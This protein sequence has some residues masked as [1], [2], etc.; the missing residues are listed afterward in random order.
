MGSVEEL[1]KERTQVR[2]DLLSGK[3]PKRVFCNP[4]FTM[5]AACDYAGINLMEA[6]YSMELTEKAY[7]K[8]CAD[9]IADCMPARNI[10]FATIYQLLGARNWITSSNGTIQHPEIETMK[11]EDYDEFIAA[12][13]KTIMGKFLPRVCAA[14]DKDPVS[15]TLNLATAYGAYKNITAAQGAVYARMGAKYG[16]VPGMITNQP[17]EAPFDFLA[18][19]LRGFKAI[20]MD[21]RRCPDKVKGAVEAI[22]P[23]MIKMATPP[24]IRPGMLT[25]IP[26][27][28]APYISMKA[29]DELYW[30]TFEKTIVDLDKIGI[31]C[32]LF[33]EQDWTRYCEYLER[34]PK[35]TVM[36]MESGDPKRFTETVG[37][38]HVFGGFYDPTITLSRS[39]E[40][41]IDEVKKLLDTCMKSDHFYFTFDKSVIDMKSVNV[42]KLQAVCEWVYE[43]GKY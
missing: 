11:V 2:N 17:I 1:I 10:R 7:D 5:E 29:F 18:D 20:T 12:P 14:L 36:F 32:S 21:I 24:A 34:L 27:H 33:V 16:Y 13:V 35:S 38:D 42:P 40:E 9:F 6:H 43:N 41:C 26:L 3:R 25:F 31:G 30:P 22:T 19:Q 37:K 4:N 15:N 39:T 23:L 8:T 28:L